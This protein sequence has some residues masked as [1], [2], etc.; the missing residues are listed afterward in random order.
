MLTAIVEQVMSKIR[1]YSVANS[2]MSSMIRRKWSRQ[3]ANITND[4]AIVLCV[5]CE[6]YWNDFQWMFNSIL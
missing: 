3:L 6:L 4:N 2:T 1:S 5:D